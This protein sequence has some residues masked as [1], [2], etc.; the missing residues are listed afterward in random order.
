MESMGSVNMRRSQV[1]LRLP[2]EH[3]TASLTL[4]DGD[5][6]DAV[7]FVSP[8]EDMPRFLTAPERFV[9]AMREGKVL[10]IARSAI[11]SL[12]V[13]AK[14]IDSE[15]PFETQTAIVR[16]RSGEVLEG[17]LRWTAPAGQ[18]RTIDYLNSDDPYLE[19]HAEGRTHYVMKSHVATVEER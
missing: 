10:L 17:E 13:P 12:G 4:E 8:N 15:L 2:V 18:Q 7:L 9:A 14:V 3:V 6:F 5:R 16:L 1:I 19:V 11:A